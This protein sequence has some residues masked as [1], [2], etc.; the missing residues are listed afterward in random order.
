MIYERRCKLLDVEPQEGRG[1]KTG[2][3]QVSPFKIRDSEYFGVFSYQK[4]G[5]NP[6]ALPDTIRLE[7]AHRDVN[8]VI[9]F[10]VKMED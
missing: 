9:E 10:A 4:W 2:H 5:M 3:I 6:V 8:K 7:F 1:S